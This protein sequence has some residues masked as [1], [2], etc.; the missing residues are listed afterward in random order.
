MRLNRSQLAVAAL[1]TTLYVVSGF[2]RT[3]TTQNYTFDEVA[4]GLK[5]QDPATR[6]RAIQIL[7]NADYA[8][9]VAAIGEV[10]GD[11]DDRVQLAALDAQYS[12]FTLRPVSRKTKVG[13]VVEK[14]TTSA[15]GDVAAEGQLALKPH[16][17]P[18]QVMTGLI[19]ALADRNPTVR[20]QA[21]GLTALLAPVACPPSAWNRAA[22]AKNVD[23]EQCVRLGNGLIENLNSRE[24][25]LQRAAM[26]ALGRLRYPDAVQALLDRFSF[27]Q[28]G[29]DA[30][31]ALEGLAG[32][33]HVAAVSTF[34]EQ[35]ANS[36][37]TVRR[38]AIEGLARAGSTDSLP[39]LQ[40]MGQTERSAPVLLALHYATIRLGAK[41]GKPAEIV[42][43]LKTPALRPFAIQYLLDLAPGMASTFA[44]SLR[45]DDPQV[46][47]VIADVL[48]FSGNSLAVPAL[49]QAAKD[50]DPDVA[51]AADRALTRL[52]L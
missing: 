31:T 25:P 52:K 50:S 49:T 39:T 41:E 35:L 11:P 9:A 28:R 29:Q 18:P 13:F 46:R 20:G 16:R 6:L 7:K 36:N 3:V 34:Q 1:V 48:G 32:T 21:I 27:F 19:T 30:V 51:S 37:A 23:R 45:D 17:V 44:E 33:G 43:A 4:A 12:L 22:S 2:S 47:R 10:L 40:Q 5:H 42:S 15:G 38:L 8:E 26:Q 14:R 24:V